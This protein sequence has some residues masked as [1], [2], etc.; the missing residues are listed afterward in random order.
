MEACC[1]CQ[2]VLARSWAAEGHAEPLCASGALT[3]V[4]QKESAKWNKKS[5]LRMMRNVSCL[6]SMWRLYSCEF[7]GRGAFAGLLCAMLSLWL[8]RMLLD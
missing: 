3:A 7:F 1:R 8:Y 6:R 4:R 2:H 5:R